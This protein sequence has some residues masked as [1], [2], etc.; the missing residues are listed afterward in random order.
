MK[1]WNPNPNLED[2]IRASFTKALIDGGEVL[3]DKVKDNTPVDTGELKASIEL[4]LEN[5]DKLEITV[6][7]DK[8]YA[9]AVEYGTI[10]KAA[11][12]FMR[13]ALIQS[14]NKI[15]KKFKGII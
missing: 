11:N 5:V 15:L 1:G 12:P 10:H 3:Q 7:T 9:A 2:N 6:E 8:E 14:K 4:Q 13:A